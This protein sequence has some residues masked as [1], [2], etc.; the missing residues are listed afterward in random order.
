MYFINEYID[1]LKII[2]IIF[3]FAILVSVY[4]ILKYP[5]RKIILAKTNDDIIYNTVYATVL[6]ILC[7]IGIIVMSWMIRGVLCLP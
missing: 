4:K 7:S 5:I 2:A 3:S 6:F 1:V